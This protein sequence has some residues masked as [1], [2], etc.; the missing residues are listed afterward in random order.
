MDHI[1]R[2][3]TGSGRFRILVADSSDSIRAATERLQ[4]SPAVTDIFGRLLTGTALMQLAQSPVDRVQCALEHD[5][6][7]GQFLADVWPGPR[8]R[9]RVAVP[10]AVGEPI[11]GMDCQI[12]VSRHA[13]RTGRMFQSHV[14]A[15]GGC[16]ADALQ[17]YLLESEQ[18]VTFLS[19]VTVLDEAH[20]VTVAGGMLV[21]ALPD[22]KREHLEEVTLCLEQARFDDLV[23]AGDTPFDAAHSLFH[24]LGLHETGTDP[25]QYGCQCSKAAAVSAVRMLSDD[26]LAALRRDGGEEVVDCDFCGEVYRVTAA[27]L[28]ASPASNT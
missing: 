24:T 5:G 2:W 4:A 27:D 6:H 10:G 14:P 9:G 7:A 12:S 17:R 16:V 19:L 15:P 13:M 20:R 18:V 28:D 22:M 23:Q 26:E 11:L 21:Q 1:K 3:M 25:F 8:V